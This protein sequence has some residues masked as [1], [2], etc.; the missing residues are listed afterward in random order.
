MRHNCYDE[1]MVTPSSHTNYHIP[2]W[3]M[4]RKKLLLWTLSFPGYTLKIR[5]MQNI[6]K[7]IA[8]VL[9]AVNVILDTAQ[10]CTWIGLIFSYTGN[11]DRRVGEPMERSQV[12]ILRPPNKTCT[13]KNSE[14]KETRGRLKLRDMV[15]AAQKCGGGNCGTSVYAQPQPYLLQLEAF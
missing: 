9:L 12:V 1:R 11:K 3:H 6:T 13:V 15:S 8:N 14:V 7:N 2:S 5:K 4:M 10:T